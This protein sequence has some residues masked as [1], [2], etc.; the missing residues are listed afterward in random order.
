MQK[1]R[2]NSCK[3]GNFT[4]VLDESRAIF[5][6]VN[7]PLLGYLVNKGGTNIT[8]IPVV[9]R[10]PVVEGNNPYFGIGRKRTGEVR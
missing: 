6:H 9:A 10:T 5:A 1:F 3:L 4:V 2:S 8:I 7:T